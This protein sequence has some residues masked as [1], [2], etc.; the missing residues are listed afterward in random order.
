MGCAPPPGL[1]PQA[2]GGV[3]TGA[4]LPFLRTTASMNWEQVVKRWLEGIATPAQRE[5]VLVSA[6][7]RIGGG[8]STPTLRAQIAASALRRQI[9]RTMLF[10]RLTAQTSK[11]R[12]SNSPAPASGTNSCVGNF[13]F[14]RELL[15][16]P[17]TIFFRKEENAMLEKKDFVPIEKCTVSS[18]MSLELFVIVLGKKLFVPFHFIHQ[19]HLSYASGDVVTPTCRVSTRASA[20]IHPQLGMNPSAFR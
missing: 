14:P 20:H 15:R 16:G 18:T 5:E 12:R 11:P 9:L 1:T 2:P 8:Q 10:S 17:S 4:P 13:A 3:A 6:L 19:N 7:A